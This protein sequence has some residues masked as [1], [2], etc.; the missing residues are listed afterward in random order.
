MTKI[1]ACG[2]RMI[3]ATLA[4]AA[5]AS[6]AAAQQA[7]PVDAAPAPARAGTEL[8]YRPA[9][10][11]EPAFT[12]QQ[13]KA[14]ARASA[15]MAR[16]DAMRWYGFSNARPVATAMPY[17]TM[18]SPAWAMPGGRPFAWYVSQRPI[19]VVTPPAP[20]YR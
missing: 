11:R 2:F 12:V 19:V 10:E 18:Y 5:V 16:L 17:T 1:F 13:Q 6:T 9:V 3:L 20:L 4:A 8:Y 15:R 7:A 14:M